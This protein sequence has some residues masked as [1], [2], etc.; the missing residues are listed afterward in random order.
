MKVFFG[1]LFTFAA[2][3]ASA[4]DPQPVVIHA[5]HILDVRNGN[6]SDAYIVVRGERIES[7]AKSAPAGAK[8]ID[9]GDATVLPGLIDCHVHLVTDWSDFSA[10]SFLRQSAP[11][12]LLFG[13]KNSWEYLDRGFTT[14][15]D[16]GEG[17]PSYGQVAL[18]DAFNKGMFRGPRMFVAGIPIS[19]TGGH[20][21]L[22]PLAP[23]V[24]LAPYSNIADTVDEVQK[25]VR[26]DVRNG[27]DW[28]KLMANGGVADPLSDYNVQELSDE[29]LRA[30]V[31]WGHRANKKVMAHAEGTQGIKAA[32]RAGVDTIEHGT[33]LDEEGAKLMAERGTWLVPTLETFQRGPEIGLTQGQEPIML[34][35]GKAI[36]KYQQAGFD[37]A[38][39]YHLK[40]AFGLD[41]DPQY[42][43]R[44]F[45]ALV[46]AGLTPLQS[47]Q[48]A[49]IN[50][51]SLLDQ[52][53]NI[54]S[55]EPGH[56][57]DIVAVDG[58]PLKDIQSMSKVVFVMKGGEVVRNAHEPPP[59]ALH[60]RHL[61]DVRTG[62][63]SDAFIVVRGDRIDS[64][65]KAAPAGAKIIDL[66][67][68]T[69]LP[70]LI[71]C[72]VHLVTDWTDLSSTGYLRLSASVRTLYGLMN[73]W[74]YLDHGFTTLRDAGEFDPAYG[75]VALRDAFN[76]GMLRGPRLFVAGF[77]VS[78]TGGHADANTLASDIAMPVWSNIA[79]S[80]GETQKAVRHDVR[81]GADWIKLMATGGVFD[82]FSDFKT[83]E[84]SEEQMRAAVE[85]GHRAHKKVMAHAEGTDGIKA[86]VRAGVDTIE[87]GTVL[88]EEGAKLMAERGTWLVPTLQTFQRAVDLGLSQGQ[89]PVMLAKGKEILKY[90]QTAF[91]WALKYHL[92]IAFGL[93]DEPKYVAREFE[94][95]VK[96][97]L[98]P[99]ESIQTATINAATLLDQSANIGSLEPGHYADIVAVDGDPLKDIKV[100]SKVVF[101]MKGGE[102]VH[103]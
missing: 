1:L 54:G 41:D 103:R 84:L 98:T 2:M 52:S 62:N 14:L 75:Q 29:Q 6:V 69:V 37:R 26:H 70:G 12:K 81:N 9:L 28:I 15:R 11:Q 71:D 73:S 88:D 5:R 58:D 57:A 24:P 86:A 20:A 46:K 34:E 102:V 27:A 39:K 97:G 50:A 53:A 96:A 30:A 79:D 93:D 66:G 83:Q 56:Y 47:L 60:T 76:K 99:L 42:V 87:H 101:V 59:T 40:I 10:T 33:V 89:E 17:D 68:A 55:L 48:A 92:K 35:K 31:E 67:D 49:T 43:A 65:A 7:I 100:M 36:L 4:A 51:A 13:L 21:D 77:P 95:L 80:V 25:A 45:T 3:T 74:T 22:N 78:L 8:V 63:V 85:Y 61:L 16:A 44:E 72:H 91:D 19:V 64:I 90:Q 38:M 18:R 32:V 82:P 23:D 94:A